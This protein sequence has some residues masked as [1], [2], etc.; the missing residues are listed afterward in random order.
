M[1][2][3]GPQALRSTRVNWLLR[4]TANPDLTAEMAQHTKETLLGVYER[5]SQQRTM[6][7][8]TRFWAKWDR[9]LTRTDALAPGGCTGNPGAVQQAPKSAPSP[10]CRKPSGCLWCEDHRDIDSQDHVWALVS[11]KHLKLIEISK[12]GKTQEDHD[13]SPARHAI[14]RLNEKLRWFTQ[15]SELRRAW[16]EEAEARILEGSYHPSWE[17]IIT[18]QEGGQ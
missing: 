18:E 6:V 17:H 14:N 3:V 10:D 7:E 11:F 8:V 1:P 13:N 15:S 9:R 5:P 12:A 2:F 16:V 4:Q